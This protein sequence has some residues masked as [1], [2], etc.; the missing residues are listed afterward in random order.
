[1][2]GHINFVLGDDDHPTSATETRLPWQRQLPSNGA[3]NYGLYDQFDHVSS[4]LLRFLELLEKSHK[5]KAFLV[6]SALV[7]HF[8]SPHDAYVPDVPAF[9]TSPT[10]FYYD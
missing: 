5:F 1:M 7:C 4:M 8:R 3:K 10:L 2:G 6:I 9:L